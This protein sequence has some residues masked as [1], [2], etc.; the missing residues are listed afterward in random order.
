M[1]RRRQ[2]VLLLTFTAIPMHSLSL[3]D[4][5]YTEKLELRRDDAAA[6]RAVAAEYVRGLHWVLEYY[7][8]CKEV[9]PPIRAVLLQQPTTVQI[10]VDCST[11]AHVPEAW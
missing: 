6:R 8:R 9:S 4:K 2:V 10:P 11:H 1:A 7:Y 3:Q 5:Y